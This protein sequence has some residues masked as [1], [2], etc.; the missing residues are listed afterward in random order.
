M[1][2]YDKWY[3]K[4]CNLWQKSNHTWCILAWEIEDQPLMPENQK[5]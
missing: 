5:Q 3:W 1:I 2:E 4:I